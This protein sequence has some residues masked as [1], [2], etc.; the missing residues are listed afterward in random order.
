MTGVGTLPVNQQLSVY[1]KLGFFR[2]NVDF[3]DG[4]GVVGSAS[5][6]GIDL[7]YGF[8]ASFNFA[9]NAALRL[10]WQRYK[11]VG[12]DNTTGQGDIDLIGVGLVLKF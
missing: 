5:A 6:S 3:K 2:W 11:D 4:T 1:G 9:K 8:G 12:D 7:T 10:E